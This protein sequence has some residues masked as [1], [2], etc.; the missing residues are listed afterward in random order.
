MSVLI[1]GNGSSFNKYS[2]EEVFNSIELIICADG[3]LSKAE[4]LGLV[5]DII[6]GDFDSVNYSIL[7]KYE[8]MNVEI[9]KY[10][11]EKDYTDME[12]A[13]DLAV[14]KGYKDMIILGATGTRLDHTMANMLLLE[15]YYKQGIKIKI[16]DNNNIIQIISDDTKLTLQYKKNYF[17]SIVPITEEINDLTLKGFKYPLN[18][19]NVKRGSTLCISNE[20]NV[21][22]SEVTLRSGTAFLI[23]A[24]D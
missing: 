19:V 5:P 10:P 17:I 18:K 20:I 14:N 16:I 9:I 7:K 1:I 2:N 12:L 6:I 23:V 21:K 13:I 11:A 15:K 3:G 8:D 4:I 22:V 24:N